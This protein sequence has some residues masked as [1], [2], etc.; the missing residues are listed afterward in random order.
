MRVRDLDGRTWRVGRRWLPWR[1]AFRDVPDVD[2]LSIPSLAV[3]EPVVGWRMSGERAAALAASL[4]E[5]RSG[6]PVTG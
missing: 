5:H 1:R 2:D 6:D 3:A 4:R